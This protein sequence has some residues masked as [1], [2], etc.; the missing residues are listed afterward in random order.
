MQAL[1]PQ[2]GSGDPQC[3]QRYRGGDQDSQYPCQLVLCCPGLKL[4]VTLAVTLPRH[5]VISPPVCPCLAF[6]ITDFEVDGGE[7]EGN[8]LSKFYFDQFSFHRM[9]FFLLF[10]ELNSYCLL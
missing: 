3:I 7:D 8:F 4:P 2:Q 9:P 1:Q 6:G 5:T 10:L